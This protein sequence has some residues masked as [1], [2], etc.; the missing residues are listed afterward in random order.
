MSTFGFAIGFAPTI[1]R[2]EKVKLIRMTG[3]SK[4][5]STLQTEL[6]LSLPQIK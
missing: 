6:E 3:F 1:R 5:K 2:Y 4:G